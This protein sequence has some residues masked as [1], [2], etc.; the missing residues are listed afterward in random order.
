MA[1]KSVRWSTV[2]VYEFGVGIG[3]T[4][5]ARHDAGEGGLQRGTDLPHAHGVVQH[6]SV[7]EALSAYRV[8][9]LSC[10]F[11]RANDSPRQQDAVLE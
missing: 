8:R 7:A 2:T 11:A 10:S 9:G 6:R 5:G 1:T 3:G 4:A